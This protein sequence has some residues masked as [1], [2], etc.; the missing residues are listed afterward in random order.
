MHEANPVEAGLE[1]E[2]IKW[3]ITPYRLV[4]NIDQ[5]LQRTIARSK[6][7]SDFSNPHRVWRVGVALKWWKKNSEEE[8]CFHKTYP[9][10]S[11][12]KNPANS[13]S[14]SSCPGFDLMEDWY[15]RQIFYVALHPSWAHE[16]F[17]SPKIR[18]LRRTLAI[19]CFFTK[20][21]GL[22]LSTLAFDIV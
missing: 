17:S 10:H 19:L 1:F 20:A 3:I 22:L 4:L 8:C 21:V 5:V 7:D 16:K 14:E 13:W 11:K 15:S 2:L 12:E 9:N 18:R 6:V